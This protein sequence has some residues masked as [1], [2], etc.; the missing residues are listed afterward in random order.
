[1]CIVVNLVVIVLWGICVVLWVWV[2]LFVWGII[3]IYG[4]EWLLGVV[5]W[6]NVK[7]C[8]G[9]VMGFNDFMLFW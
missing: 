2:K 9:V 1:M 7:V 6:S 8:G 4:D 3:I 5:I